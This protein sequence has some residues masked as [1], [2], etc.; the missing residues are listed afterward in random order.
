MA[1]N[2]NARQTDE[3][4][5]G[6]PPMH[7][8][9]ESWQGKH[10]KDAYKD[11]KKAHPSNKLSYDD[12]CQTDQV[13]G[14]YIFH[15]A[16]LVWNEDGDSDD[17]RAKR[18]RVTRV[19]DHDPKKT[20][21]TN[22]NG[23]PCTAGSATPT[24]VAN[25]D[26]IGASGKRKR[27]PRKKYMSQE[28]VASDEEP[29]D[30]VEAATPYAEAESAAAP[31]ITVNGRRKSSSR[32]PRK[33]PISNETISPED[34]N[35]DPMEVDAPVITSPLPVRSAPHAAAATRQPESPKKTTPKQ[36]SVKKLRKSFLVR[37][38]FHLWD[39]VNLEEKSEEMVLDEDTDNGDASIA[40]VS[41]PATIPA[42]KP[43]VHSSNDIK[44]DTNADDA[45]E[46]ATAEG[47]PDPSAAS[48]RRGLRNRKPAQ[49]RP[50]YHDAQVFED[51]ET[52]SEDESELEPLSREPSP[53]PAPLSKAK[54]FKGKGR[55]WKKD[56]SDED[57]EFV[58]P[59]EK[60]AAKAAKAKADKAKT[61]AD[62]EAEKD[63]LG[64]L[65][66]ALVTESVAL[67]KKEPENDESD[68]NPRIDR[69]LDERIR[70]KDLPNVPPKQKKKIG[71]PRKSNL[72][73]DIVRDESDNDTPQAT[74]TQPPKRG[75]GRPRKSALSSEIVR[76]DS[77][78]EAPAQ[79]ASQASA[80]APAPKPAE[81]DATIDLT[82]PPK[83]KPTSRPS[84]ATSSAAA[85]S[86]APTPKKRG[87]PRKSETSTTPAKAAV[88]K[89][90]EGAVDHKPQR[91]GSTAT[92]T[93][94]EPKTTR[95]RASI[96]S[97]PDVRSTAQAPEY[98]LPN[99]N[100]GAALVESLYPREPSR[101][102]SQAASPPAPAEAKE[103]VEPEAKSEAQGEWCTEAHHQPETD[104]EA[105]AKAEAAAKAETEAETEAKGEGVEEEDDGEMSAAMSL[106]SDSE[107]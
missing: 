14:G 56:G 93:A 54:H 85:P 105:K 12:W 51:V 57:E 106:S 78:D 38:P 104:T 23:T 63:I 107:L 82:T 64:S 98:L 58:T 5:N 2:G 76:D 24:P 99:I 83:P 84:T 92:E 81:T 62:K 37:L 17:E 27:K 103:T 30:E 67:Y 41:R 88:A 101:Q 77:E 79:A 42:A 100:R 18:R 39:A 10:G 32:K 87:R 28:L 91:R 1:L 43:K 96:S 52:E 35:V 74:P 50:Y 94:A 44:T 13:F 59:K 86:Q 71:R 53:E 36:A 70:A 45:A 7:A 73:E 6:N 72:S 102:P 34:E 25:S 95:A 97:A 16:S 3:Y 26:E 66:D 48:A 75:R 20:V 33:K 46:T 55:A 65:W 19:P 80:P 68:L 8:S 90:S 61:K 15:V 11:F 49:Q 31:A 22:G 69:H 40:E 4:W 47:T 89:P 29:A 60:K 9:F 21:T